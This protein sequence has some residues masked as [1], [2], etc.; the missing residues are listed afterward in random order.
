MDSFELNLGDLKITFD[1]FC[2]T[3][4]YD[5]DDIP[6]RPSFHR[7]LSSTSSGCDSQM[8][9]AEADMDGTSVSEFG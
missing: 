9:V 3:L 4:P 8:D 2:L 7:T 6:S 1:F 5:F